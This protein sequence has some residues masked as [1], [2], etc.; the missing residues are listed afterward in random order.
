MDQ[1][2]EETIHFY[3]MGLDDR[4]LNAISHLRW[5]T[6]T[7]IQEKA[8]PLALEGNDILAR[9]RTGTG[10][11]A[12]FAIPII[13]G[14]LKA[15]ST[16]RLRE[17][18][19][20]ILA[21]SKEL[22]SQIAN[23]IKMLTKF[24]SR[25]VLT[26]DVS[27]GK[28]DDLKSVIK[29][30]KPDIIIGTPSR[31][32][33]HGKQLEHLKK[34]LKFLVID[35]AD[36]M[37]SFGYEKDLQKVISDFV[38]KIGCQAFLM[39]ATLNL[40][41]KN[42]KKLVLHNP[43]VLKLQEPELP[44]SDKLIQYHIQCEEEEKF[45]LLNAM[46]KLNLIRGKTIIFVRTVDR[47]YK[48][49]LFLEQFGI[50]CCIL[51]SELPVASRCFVVQ[52]FNEGVYEIIL[53]SDEKCVENPTERKKRSSLGKRKRD[54]EYGVSRGIDFHFVSNIINFDFPDSIDTYIHRVGRAA[55]GH[56]SDE[57]TALSF[58]SIKEKDAFEKVRSAFSSNP[59][60]KAYQFKMEELEAFRYRSR[61]ALRAVTS[62]A[63]REA[64]IKEIKRE[65]LTSRTLKS[66]FEENPKD[67]KVLKHDKALHTV[68]HKSHLKDVP[69]YI[70]PETLQEVIKE[71]S[72][73]RFVE[74]ESEKQKKHNK[75]IK[76]NKTNKKANSNKKQNDPLKTFKFRES[77]RKTKK[78]KSK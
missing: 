52:Q 10:K 19:A 11:T 32:I 51:N 28:P 24:C 39:S 16:S 1:D 74:K 58:I 40:E 70:V 29:A 44:E 75:K 73:K 47:C 67:H 21:P 66:Y 38:P 65:L 56:D 68:K 17:T 35:E 69:E 43:V 2:E 8:I 4:I 37:F 50:N 22:C 71:G 7:L 63:I 34:E 62:I 30:E 36:L 59:N 18:L 64:R 3:E 14:I 48:L 54:E 41:V 33:M 23:H 45:V 13:N 60:F 12:A 5:T 27:Q 46:F 25:D 76:K 20:L 31:I 78:K 9:A 15:K 6:P 72:K 42:L 26:I 49:K 55:R 77:K 61:D 53:A 57:G